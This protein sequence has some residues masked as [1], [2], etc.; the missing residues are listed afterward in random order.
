LDC[1]WNCSRVGLELARLP[2]ESFE[3]LR[4]NMNFVLEASP[5][6]YKETISQVTKLVFGQLHPYG[7]GFHGRGGEAP[8]A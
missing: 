7:D 5:E 3:H 6:S 1:G 8:P 4:R 2:E